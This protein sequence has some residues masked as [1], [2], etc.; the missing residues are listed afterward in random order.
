[1]QERLDKIVNILDDKKA[2]DIESFDL[3]GKNYIADAVIV[4]T[5]L[6]NKH[7]YSM[8]GYLKNGLKPLGEEFLRIDEDDDWTIIDLG[9]IIIHLMSQTYRDRYDLDKFLKENS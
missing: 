4:A 9:D 8:L 7:A 3:V 5:T 6:N 1:M 2:V